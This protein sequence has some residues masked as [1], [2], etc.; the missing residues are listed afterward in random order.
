[1]EGPWAICGDFNTTRYVSEK[2][3]CNRRSR[4]M[5]E[6]S[7]FIEDMNLIDLQLQDGNYTWFKGDNHDTA[8]SS[9]LCKGFNDRIKEWWNSFSFKGRPDFVLSCKLKALK[10]K[11]KD[12]SRSE[13]GNL[14]I[15]RKQ[16]LEQLAEMDMIL[17]YRPLKEQESAKKADLTLELEGLIKNEEVAW[18][19]KSRALWLKEGDRNTKFFHKVANAHKRFNYI[20]QLMVQGELT[21]ESTRIESAIID[22]Y[23]KLYTETTHW[24]PINMLN[25]CATLSVENKDIMNAFHNFHEQEVFERSFN[26]TFI[27]LI[28]KKKGAKE[29]RDYRPISLIG[30]IYK[31][32]SKVLTERLKGVISNL[33]D[34]QQMAFIKG[35]QIMD[36]VLVA[37]EAIDSRVQQTK[38]GI[39]CKLDI[40]KA[41]DHVNWEYLL[42]MLK[43]L[44]FGKKWIHWIKFCISTVSYSVLINGSPAGF[45]KAQRGLRQGDPL[46]PFLFI[47]A[48]EGLNSMFKTANLYGWIKGFEVA[49]AG[50]DSL[51]VTHLQYADDTLIFCDADR[52]Q[53]RHLRIILVLFKGISGLHINWGKSFLYPINDV[54]HMILMASILGGEKLARWKTQY[55]SRGGRLTLINSVLDA[56]PTYM[57]SLFP[58]PAGVIKRLDR[59]RRNFL[60]H[61]DKEKKGYH[62]VKWSSVICDKKWGGL[63]IKNLKIQ[64]TALMM[65][66]LWKFTKENHLLWGRV[67]KAKYE[68][69]DSWMTKEVNTPYGVSLWR[70]IRS[71]RSELKTQSRINVA[72]GNKTRFWKDNWHEVGIMELVFPDIFNLVLHQQYTIAEMWTSDGWSLNFRRHC[73]DWEVQRVADFLS[74]LD[75]FPGVQAGE[76]HLWWQGNSKGIFKVNAAYKIM[77]QSNQRIANWPWKQIW[78][79]KAPHKVSIFVWLLAKEATLTVDNLMSRGMTLCSRC[80]LCKETAETVNHLFLHCPFTAHLWRIIINLKGIA[81]TMPG[82]I[83]EALSSWEGICSHAKI[84]VDG[85]LSQLVSGGQSGRR[86]IPDVLRA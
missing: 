9:P 69:E 6:F 57:M 27:T 55:L 32:F 5:I 36:A 50:S 19:Q 1:M 24:R 82:K 80:F 63:G 60:W 18:R 21:E 79:I 10:H 26:A 38:P 62:L 40:E 46:S 28:P 37:N 42:R 67:I 76:D 43:K 86:G 45:F 7:D 25:N 56:L 35:R 51:E 11:L 75:Q 72:N 47:I 53:L 20:D 30:S 48:M 31:L 85:E 68:Q 70:S 22:F 52:N 73:N 77:N 34:V 44:G 14:V 4:G 2:R 54:P 29:L 61:G 84:G 64:S 3:N 65:K 33:V 66:W 39:L 15:Q 23:Q 83:T 71:L 17:E 12:W 49:R 58:I 16:T 74:K 13:A 59:I 81:W 41:Y 78:R 8:S